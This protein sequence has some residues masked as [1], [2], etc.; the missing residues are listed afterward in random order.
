MKVELM[1]LSSINEGVGWLR[2]L[3]FEFPILKKRIPRVLIHC[4]NTAII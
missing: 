3:L 1:P 2:D 4:D